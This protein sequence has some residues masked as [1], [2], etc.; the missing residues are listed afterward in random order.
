MILILLFRL[1]CQLYH[2]QV[3]PWR[4]V[5]SYFD[6]I[7]SDVSEQNSRNVCTPS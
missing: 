6:S 4:A 7:F 5:D 1:K 3:W 2:S